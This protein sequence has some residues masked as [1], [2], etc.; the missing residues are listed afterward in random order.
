MS[1]VF[2]DSPL[3]AAEDL[4]RLFRQ[5]APPGVVTAGAGVGPPTDVGQRLDVTANG[6]GLLTI[7]TGYCLVGGYWYRITAPITRS[8]QPNTSGQPRRD[9]VVVR[10]DP[11]ADQVTVVI[12]PGSPGSGTAPAPTREGSGV[13][14][15]VLAVVTVAGGSS[16]VMPGDVDT[17]PR[18]YA[19]SSGA[20][21]CLSSHRPP[22]P[23]DGM[24]IYETD[25]GRVLVRIGDTWRVVSETDY[26]TDWQPITLRTG[27]TTPGHGRSPSWRF[28]SP[29][30][31]ELRGTISRTNGAALPSNDYYARMPAAARPGAWVRG[32]G[33]AESRNSGGNWGA[34]CRLEVAS[35]NASNRLPGQVIAFHNQDPR[36]IAL[37]NFTYDI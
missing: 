9:L 12:I 6:T 13:W 2:A 28:L 15:V 8:I 22:A 29:G 4:A 5:F 19:A 7:G 17:R 32:T 1:G 10:A 30:R 16:V 24:L 3:D 11:Q 31:V 21:P 37:D 23:H 36:W 33:A 34:T 14:D 35:E 20:V 27:Y 26:P 18:E 25:T